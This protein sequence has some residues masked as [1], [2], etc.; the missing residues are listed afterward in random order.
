M[1]KIDSGAH[2]R[3]A[4]GCR[5]P[6]TSSA[7]VAVGGLSELVVEALLDG[8]GPPSVGFDHVDADRSTTTRSSPC[9]Y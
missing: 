2:D 9:T 7:P 6:M 4:N 3:P 5:S 8:V 1:R